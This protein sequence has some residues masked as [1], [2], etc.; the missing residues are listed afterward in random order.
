MNFIP[1][2]WIIT[3]DY[4]QRIGTLAPRCPATMSALAVELCGH[5]V[6]CVM[7]SASRR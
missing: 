4:E 1:G 5:L 2:H 3:A 7:I 6:V